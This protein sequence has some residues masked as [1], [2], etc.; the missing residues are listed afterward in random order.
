[1]KKE[2]QASKPEQGLTLEPK[3]I[4]TNTLLK[5]KATTQRNNDN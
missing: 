2:D 1:M 4:E 3:A 5:N